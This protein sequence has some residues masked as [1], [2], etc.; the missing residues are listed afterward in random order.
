MKSYVDDPV[1]TY[2]EI[3]DTVSI[4]SNDKN[5]VYKMFLF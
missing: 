1:I 4:N 5:A 3:I 2:A